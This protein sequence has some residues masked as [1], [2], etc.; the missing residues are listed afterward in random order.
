MYMQFFLYLKY[1]SSAYFHVNSKLSETYL[2]TETKHLE[3][4][5]WIGYHMT[6]YPLIV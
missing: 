2:N 6:F 5:V 1:T 3:V 4:L